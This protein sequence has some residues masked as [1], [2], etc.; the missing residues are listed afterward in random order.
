MVKYVLS[1]TDT[2]YWPHVYFLNMNYCPGANITDIPENSVQSY[3]IPCN[4]VGC[5]VHAH[6]I[7]NR[8]IGMEV[9]GNASFTTIKKNHFL[10]ATTIKTTC[11]PTD[12][13]F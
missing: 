2:Y 5:N 11:L 12:L 13:Y 4:T 7:L 9:I 3:H 8:I 6:L 1:T 10:N